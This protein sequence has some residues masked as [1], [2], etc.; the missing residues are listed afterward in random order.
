MRPDAGEM[1]WHSRWRAAYNG[2]YN[3]GIY[4]TRAAPPGPMH[5]PL[6]DIRGSA[7]RWSDSHSCASLAHTGEREGERERE[8]GRERE[9]V[10]VKPHCH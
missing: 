8:R 3:R 2:I 1:A 5:I 7:N 4:R 9:R 10:L 6:V